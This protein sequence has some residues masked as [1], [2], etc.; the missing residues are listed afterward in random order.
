MKKTLLFPLFLFFCIISFAQS[1]RYHFAE[2]FYFV[3]EISVSNYKGKQFRYEIAVRSNPTDSF[4]K[5]R[6]HGIASGKG[7]EDFIKSNFAI[8]SRIEQEWTIYTIAGQVQDEAYKLLFYSSVN[9]N[10]DYYFDDVNFYI[11]EQPG[12]W[13]QLEVFNPSFEI[14]KPDIFAGYYVSKRRSDGLNVHLSNQIYKTGNLSL[15]VKT[16]G[17][18][19]VSGIVQKV[20][21]KVPETSED[22]SFHREFVEIAPDLMLFRTKKESPEKGPLLSKSQTK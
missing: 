13:K 12:K 16:S 19:P 7:K 8:E 4:S 15:N 21:N 14:R 9:G 11:E 3:K 2:E 1:T 17:N 5:I 18:I 6:V 20:I 22:L 10:G